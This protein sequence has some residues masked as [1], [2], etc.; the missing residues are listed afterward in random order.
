MC[1]KIIWTTLKH[2]LRNW[3]L[4]T[5]QTFLGGHKEKKDVEDEYDKDFKRFVTSV[6]AIGTSVNSIKLK[7]LSK[8]LK[9]K[10][11]QHFR[12]F[13]YKL[14]ATSRYSEI[15]STEILTPQK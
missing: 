14:D 3:Q 5:R 1:V 13:A 4:R 15:L 7:N 9:L 6:Q 12:F 11:F 2:A 8:E 10:F